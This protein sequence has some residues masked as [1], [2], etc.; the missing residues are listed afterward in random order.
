MME[1]IFNI[2]YSSWVNVEHCWTI[3]G[4]W[5]RKKFIDIKDCNVHHQRHSWSLIS[6]TW[7]AVISQRTKFHGKFKW[8]SLNELLIFINNNNSYWFPLAYRINIIMM[9]PT[10]EA[11]P[12]ILSLSHM[13]IILCWRELHAYSLFKFSFAFDGLTYSFRK[14][15]KHIVFDARPSDSKISHMSP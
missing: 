7:Q 1:I 14:I 15:I 5:R 3:C 10:H 2:Q 4:K 6:A 11:R 13:Q 9:Y 12:W 8:K